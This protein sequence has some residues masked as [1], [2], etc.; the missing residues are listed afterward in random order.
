MV[1][2]FYAILARGLGIDSLDFPRAVFGASLAVLSN[3]LPI[4]GFAGFGTQDM[5]WVVGFGALGV[6]RDL[7]TQ[8]ALAF[9]LIYLTSILVFGYL[10]HA[11]LAYRASRSPGQ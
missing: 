8:S 4:N 3:L 6:E 1:Y 5:G 10:G 2:L 7:A 9:H 11:A